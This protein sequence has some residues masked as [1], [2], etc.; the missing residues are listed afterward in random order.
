MA[1]NEMNIGRGD[2]DTTCAG[3][4][5]RLADA[6]ESPVANINKHH[7]ARGRTKTPNT[8]FSSARKVIRRVRLRLSSTFPE[9]P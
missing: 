8:V 9:C 5:P 2:E 6:G 3:E 7:P 1:T 4:D